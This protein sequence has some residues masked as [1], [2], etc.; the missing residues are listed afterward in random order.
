MASSPPAPR[1]STRS[2]PNLPSSPDASAV[3][4]AL[5]SA[6]FFLWVA[7][8]HRTEGAFLFCPLGKSFPSNRATAVAKEEENLAVHLRI[9][10]TCE[11][12]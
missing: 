2:L 3:D 1:S 6:A 12:Q 9:W 11:W 10:L 8:H 7:P 5:I 4:A